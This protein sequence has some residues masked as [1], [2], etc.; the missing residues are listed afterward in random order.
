[1]G[2]WAE[3]TWASG[4]QVGLVSSSQVCRAGAGAGHGSSLVSGSHVGCRGGWTEI[5]L[6]LGSGLFHVGLSRG[7]SWAS[8]YG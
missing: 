8:G 2:Y 1:M 6:G 3:E 5:C 4:L 7:G